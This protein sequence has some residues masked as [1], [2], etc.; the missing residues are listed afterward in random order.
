MKSLLD[1][2]DRSE[3]THR[4]TQLRP[5]AARRW[6]RMSAHQMICHLTDS[7]YACLG[8]RPVEDKSTPFTRTFLRLVAVTVPMPWPKGVATMPEVD[9]EREGTPPAEFEADLGR[10]QTAMDAFVERMDPDS[11]KHPIF[12]KMSAAQWGRW[13]YRHVDHHLRQFGL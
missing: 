7:F 11:L 3:I 9:Q 13:A 8:D 10:L 2:R 6:G 5:D 1:T 4:V 12:H